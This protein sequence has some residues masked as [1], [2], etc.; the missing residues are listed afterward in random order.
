MRARPVEGLAPTLPLGDAA[1]RIVKVRTAEVYSFV[2]EALGEQ[3]VEAMHEMRIAAKRLRYVLELVGFT[4]GEV[5][6]E[7]QGRARDLQEVLGDIHDC[8]VM[9]ERIAASRAREPDGFDALAERVGARRAELLARFATLWASID[10]SG[11]HARL[12]ETTSSSPAQQ[13]VSA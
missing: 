2:P 10:A 1:R 9:L 8:D 6:A 4:L 13:P 7:A 3:A 12:L 11:L 5:G